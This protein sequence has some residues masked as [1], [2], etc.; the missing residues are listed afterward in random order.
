[1]KIS[2]WRLVN[3]SSA[4]NKS[5]RGPCK[6]RESYS[7]RKFVRRNSKTMTKSMNSTRLS[8][9]NL[10]KRRRCRRNHQNKEKR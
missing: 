7:R 1:L 6:E 4:K 3:I 5:N 10:K 9:R 2:K 8:N